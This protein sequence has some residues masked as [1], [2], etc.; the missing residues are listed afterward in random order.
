[1]CGGWIAEFMA[2]QGGVRE[3]AEERHAVISIKRYLEG[4][5]AAKPANEPGSNELGA[6]AVDYYRALLRAIGKSAVR[7]CQA[8]GSNLAEQLAGLEGSLSRRSSARA[9]EELQVQ[10]E[11]RLER[12]GNLTAE[13]LKGKADEVKELLMMLARTAE[14]VGDRDQRYTRQFGDLTVD[15]QAIAHLDDLSQI[16]A[17][18]MRK[19]AE[20]K[21]CIDTMTQEGQQSLGELRTRVSAYKTRLKAV[22]TLAMKDAL[23]GLANRRSA[24]ARMDWYIARQQTYCVAIVDLNCF[25]SVNDQY[26]HGAGD[27]LLRKFGAELQE[28]MRFTDMVAR[29]GGD[30]FMVVLSCDLGGARPQVERIRHSVLGKYTIQAEEGKDGLQVN[31]EASIGLAQWVSGKSSGQVIEEADAAMYLEKKQVRAKGA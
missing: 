4:N 16:R 27:D 26:G 3:T 29:W 9:L 8:P 6:A 2:R 13:H 19:A 15:L 18:V 30:E 5:A 14:S 10:V 23:T 1:M 21:S 22:E 11:E 24:E 25:K 17:S 7:A 20:L 31:V 12:W 28:N